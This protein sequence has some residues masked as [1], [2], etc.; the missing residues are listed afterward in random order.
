[1]LTLAQELQALAAAPW[2]LRSTAGCACFV[3]YSAEWWRREYKR[4]PWRW[5]HILE[6]TGQPFTLDVLE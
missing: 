5:T 6:S 2:T 4:G 1:M 3:L